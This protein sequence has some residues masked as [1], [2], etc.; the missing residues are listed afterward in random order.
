M[1]FPLR[2][3]TAFLAHSDF[4]KFTNPKHLD[5]PFASLM[6]IALVI[7]PND[8]NSFSKSL[9]LKCFGKFFTYTLVKLLASPVCSLSC[10]RM[11]NPT[12]IFCPLANMPFRPLI[13]SL[14]DDSLSNCINP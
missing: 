4:S 12:N 7:A 3:L 6:T 9:S 11:N 14:A 5:N 1:D 2:F 8:E 10:R 13:A